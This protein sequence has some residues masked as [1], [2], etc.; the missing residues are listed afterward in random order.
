MFGMIKKLFSDS[1]DNDLL[2]EISRRKFLA[3][4]Q[5]AA[6]NKVFKETPVLFNQYVMDLD[7]AFKEFAKNG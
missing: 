2:D 1:W 4:T 6:K 7:K 5:I 3:Y